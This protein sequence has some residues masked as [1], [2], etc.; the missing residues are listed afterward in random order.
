[1]KPVNLEGVQEAT[2]GERLPAGGYICQMISAEDVPGKQYLKIQY[3]IVYGDYKGYFA[4][5][6]DRMKGKFWAGNFI[7]SY[8]EDALP[9]FKGFLTVVEQSNKGFIVPDQFSNEETLKGKYVGIVLAEEEY[10]KNDGTKGTRLYAAN[11]LSVEKIK[12][13]GYKVPELK[14]L[15]ETDSVSVQNT[16]GNSMGAV[17]KDEDFPF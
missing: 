9:F 13:H 12:N 8:K 10:V 6:F 16:A 2:G 4:T 17:M 14:K 1:M 3:D 7:K 11:F 5:L 15:P